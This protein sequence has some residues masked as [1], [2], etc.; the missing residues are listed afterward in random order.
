MRQ[1][2]GLDTIDDRRLMAVFLKHQGARLVASAACGV[3]GWEV[4]EQALREVSFT[5]LEFEL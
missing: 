1:E 3:C 5:L 2:K 4:L